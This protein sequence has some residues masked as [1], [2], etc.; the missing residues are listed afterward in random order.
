VVVAGGFELSFDFYS[1]HADFLDELN[2]GKNLWV[3]LEPKGICL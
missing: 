1:W 2:F 3:R